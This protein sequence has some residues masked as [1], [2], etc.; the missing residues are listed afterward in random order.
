MASLICASLLGGK[1]ESR[2]SV[3]QSIPRKGSTEAGPL[4][5]SSAMD[6]FNTLK[7]NVVHE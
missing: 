1:Q 5:L 2:H 6:M 7:M 3:S 4:R